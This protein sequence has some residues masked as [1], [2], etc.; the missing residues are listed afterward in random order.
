MQ[1][2]NEQNFLKNIQ[3][4]TISCAQKNNSF[5][6]QPGNKHLSGLNKY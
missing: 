5:D 4:K 1:A 3:M 6:P 2:L